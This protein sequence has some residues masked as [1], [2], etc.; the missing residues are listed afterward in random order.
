MT[1]FFIFLGG[2]L[3][4]LSCKRTALKDGFIHP[5]MKVA[6]SNFAIGDSLS[7]NYFDGYDTVFT[8]K[9]HVHKPSEPQVSF[10]K[11]LVHI[12]KNKAGTAD[13]IYLVEKDLVYNTYFKASFNE[14]VTWRINI[15]NKSTGAEKT[16]VG[17]SSKIDSSNSSWDGNADG[18]VYFYAGDVATVTL[19]IQGYPIQFSDTIIIGNNQTYDSA[20]AVLLNDFDNEAK[21]PNLYPFGD[22]NDP[23]QNSTS[24]ITTSIIPPQGTHCYLLKGNDNNGDYFVGGFTQQVYTVKP[25]IFANHSISDIYFNMYVYGFDPSSGISSK[26][27]RIAVSIDQDDNEDGNY[28]G[29]HENTFEQQVAV[30]W[31]GWRLVSVRYSNLIR[32]TSKDNGGSGTN[33]KDPS[34][35]YAVKVNLLSSPNGAYV[36]VAIDYLIVTF[37]KPYEK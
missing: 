2:L 7:V 12:R 4:M 16:I 36:G 15:E 20:Q 21:T 19:S 3:L 10:R 8:Y 22:K 25:S 13:T 6:S 37:G 27:T 11:Q 26:S 23:I 34:K 9:T 24:T 35:V 18:L 14:V 28:D 31:V 29:N 30:D 1:R 17:L 5:E 32:A 33:I